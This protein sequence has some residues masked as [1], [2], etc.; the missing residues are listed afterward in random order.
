MSFLNEDTNYDFLKVRKFAFALSAIL[1]IASIVSFFTKGLNY[2]LD[3]TGGTLVEVGYEQDADLPKI[4]QQLDDINI[5]GA[6]VQNFGSAKVV[7]IRMPQQDHIENA[8]VSDAVL[9][10]LAS[11]G[12]KVIKRDQSFVGPVVGEELKEQGGL[13]MIVAL[14]CIM[15]YVALRFEWKF[16]VG[17]VA[18]LAHD[19][20]IVVGFFSI[21][22]VEF[23]LTVLAALLAV[24]GYSLNDTIVVFDRIRENFLLMRKATPEEVINNSINLTLSRT[25]MTSLTTM[26]VLLALFFFGGQTIHSFAEALIVGVLIGTYS[27]VF[28]ASP[29]TLALGVSKEDLMPPEVEKEGEEFDAL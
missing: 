11:D 15:I 9:A 19:V 14:I 3:F 21:T 4:R 18:A 22:S 5:N 7:Q 25:V 6:V 17:S 26:L 29:T 13:A 28:I 1:I 23:D 12:S 16:S 2:G 24:I 10:A 8:K 27:S 20:I